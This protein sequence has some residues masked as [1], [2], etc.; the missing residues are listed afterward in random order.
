MIDKIL[1]QLEIC[2]EKES[3]WALTKNNSLEVYIN[4]VKVGN[5]RSSFITLPTEIKRK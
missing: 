5:N 1:H 2:E 4:K 3:G